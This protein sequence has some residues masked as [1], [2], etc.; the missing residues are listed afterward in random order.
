MV[1]DDNDGMPTFEKIAYMNTV[2]PRDSRRST[3]HV[4]L[5]SF[6]AYE[7]PENKDAYLQA[8]QNSSM[9]SSVYDTCLAKLYTALSAA[10]DAYNEYLKAGFCLSVKS[11]NSRLVVSTAWSA[12]IKS[13]RA[14]SLLYMK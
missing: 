13:L 2:N 7:N 14:F 4:L 11:S 9:A 8:L 5:T 12:A 10:L 3:E 6:L 1:D